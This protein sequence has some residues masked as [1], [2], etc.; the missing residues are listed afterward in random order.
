VRQVERGQKAGARTLTLLRVAFLERS[1][2]KRMATASLQTSGSMLTNSFWPPRSQMEK[3]ISVLR[4]EMV[5]SMKFTPKVCVYS[6]LYVF[7]TYL[8]IK[9]R[10]AR[11]GLWGVMEEAQRSTAQHLH[12]HSTAQHQQIQNPSPNPNY[13]PQFQFQ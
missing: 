2:M 13:Y 10:P 7:S 1:N 8:T 5:F 9:L 6:S 11:K 12:Q 4:M 3:V